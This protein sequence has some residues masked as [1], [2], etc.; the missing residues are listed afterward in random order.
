MQS[1]WYD[2]SMPKQE[3]PDRGC[4][5]VG[6][7]GHLLFTTRHKV[8]LSIAEVARRAG[9]SGPF[10]VN[11]EMGLRAPVLAKAPLIADAYGID[12]STA[13]WAWIATWAPGT[14]PHLVNYSTISDSPFLRD[15]YARDYVPRTKAATVKEIA[16]RVA[17]S[18]ARAEKTSVNQIATPSQA[19][20][21]AGVMARRSAPRPVVADVAIPPAAR[22]NFDLVG[23]RQVDELNP[24]QSALTPRGVVVD[25]SGTGKRK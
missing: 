6:S 17:E 20:Q 10:L 12:S 5:P 9:L 1:F 24:A 2:S 3:R 25:E 14:I 13:C 22:E 11:I 8:G 23:Y 19:A 4:A 18:A 21:V 16:R 15:L 7:F